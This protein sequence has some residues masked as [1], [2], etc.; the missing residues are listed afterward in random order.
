MFLVHVA[1]RLQAVKAYVTDDVCRFACLV[2]H[3][4]PVFD[5]IASLSVHRA[6]R[7]HEARKHSGSLVFH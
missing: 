5:T 1:R 3:R 6:G 7:K 2:C 4:R